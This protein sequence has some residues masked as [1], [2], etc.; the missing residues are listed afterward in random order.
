MANRRGKTKEEKT[1]QLAWR[2]LQNEN[3]IKRR[4]KMC[5]YQKKSNQTKH[6]RRKA[7]ERA[8]QN[9]EALG[10]AHGL[11][12]SVEP[13]NVRLNVAQHRSHV[14]VVAGHHLEHVSVR[15]CD[16]ARMG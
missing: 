9:F 16:G 6:E 15:L 3:A 12:E 14:V 10:V 7:G 1:K 4:K 8:H 5:M 13:I 11:H 2:V